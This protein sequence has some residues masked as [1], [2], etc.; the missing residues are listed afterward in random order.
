MPEGKERG[1]GKMGKGT[2]F[3]TVMALAFDDGYGET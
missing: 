1:G 3:S 2:Y